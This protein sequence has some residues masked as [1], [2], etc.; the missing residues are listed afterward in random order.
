EDITGKI[1]RYWAVRKENILV[2]NGSAELI[3]LAAIAFKPRTATIPV[4]AFCEYERAAK[5]VKSKIKFLKLKEEEGFKLDPSRVSYSDMIFLCNPNNPT[6]DITLNDYRL[7]RRLPNR[8]IIVDE[9]FM[10]FLPDDKRQTLIRNVRKDRRIIVLR[11]FTKF[12]ALPGLR[13]GY[14]VAHKDIITRLRQCQPPWSVNVFAQ[15]AAAPALNDREYAR[16]SLS[17]MEKERRFLFNRIA[18]FEKLH[19][20]SSLT[21]FLLIKIKDRLLTSSLLTRKLLSK[22]IL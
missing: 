16:K 19:P 1:A 14:A 8:L 7:I 17:M 21:N 6:G 5:A 4:P 2:G 9:A 18:G 13:I 12:F 10:D 3:Y 22:G 20:Y 15:L 11:T